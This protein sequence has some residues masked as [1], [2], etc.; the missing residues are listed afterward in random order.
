[1]IRYADME[2]YV[3]K[4]LETH[5]FFG[6]IMKEHAFFLQVSFPEI[7]QSYKRQASWYRVRFEQI[8]DITVRLANGKVSK[9]VLTSGEVVTRYTQKVERQTTRFTGVPLQ[10]GI[11]QA[12]QR[13]K[14]GYPGR[15]DKKTVEQIRRINNKVLGLLE[16]LISLKERILQDVLS[17]RVFTTNYPLLIEHILREARW[18]RQIILNIENGCFFEKD[19]R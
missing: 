6:R 13:L 15:V 12:E 3:V 18:Y 14:S 4:S 8:L 10:I 9:N 11:T 5:L 7:E 2:T 1:M 16:G 17:C 19:S